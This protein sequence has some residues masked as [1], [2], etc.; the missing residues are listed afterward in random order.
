MWSPSLTTIEV[1][2]PK[3]CAVTL[4]Y[5]VGLISPEAVTSDINVSDGPT[6]AVCT[7]TTPLLAWVTLIPTIAPRTTTAP[8][9]IPTF[10]HVFIFASWIPPRALSRGLQS[11]LSTDTFTYG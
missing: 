3:P 2:R 6:F 9:P 7:V 1:I 10:C 5:V 4:V 8:T 11:R